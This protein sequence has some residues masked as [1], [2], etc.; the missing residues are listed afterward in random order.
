MNRKLAAVLPLS[1]LFASNIYALTPVIIH[2]TLR[3]Y[4]ATNAIAASQLFGV[5]MPLVHAQPGQWR[6][7]FSPAYNTV[8]AAPVSLT[9]GSVNVGYTRRLG[10]GWGFYGLVLSNYVRTNDTADSGRANDRLIEPF[11]IP[12]SGV[13]YSGAFHSGGGILTSAQSVGATYTVWRQR[14]DRPAI[15]LFGGPVATQS[16]A[17]GLHYDYLFT[18]IL[19]AYLRG[20]ILVVSSNGPN[21]RAPSRAGQRQRRFGHDPS[22]RVQR[23]H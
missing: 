12:A 13:S 2:S 21:G 23:S 18:G 22:L 10:A 1:V 8:A 20:D 19:P 17:R 7:T 6:L 16:V 4:D 3:Y 9:G 14:G 11:L 15:T 5:P